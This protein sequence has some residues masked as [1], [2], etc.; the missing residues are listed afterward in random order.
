M[1][2]KGL[3]WEI[4]WFTCVC[5]LVWHFI[6]KR[7]FLLELSTCV[8]SFVIQFNF[9]V[10]V[11]HFWRD[12]DLQDLISSFAIMFCL[13]CVYKKWMSTLTEKMMYWLESPVLCVNTVSFWKTLANQ[14]TSQKMETWDLTK[15][16]V[17]KL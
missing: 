15:L 1:R 7:L 10:I 2:K 5:K 6:A 16:G 3:C 12:L 11:N 17:W 14:V 13:Q 8:P 9:T 4:M